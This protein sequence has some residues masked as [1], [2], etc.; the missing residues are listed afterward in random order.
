MDWPVLYERKVRFS[1]T[2]AQGVVFNGMYATY[3]DDTITDY[4]DAIGVPWSELNASGHD[5]VL[6][7]IEIDFRSSGR[8]GEVLVTGARVKRIGNSSLVFELRT[9][10]QSSGRT[11]AEAVQVQ[12]I[13]DH[14]TFKP[15]PVPSF[16]SDAVVRTQGPPPER[17][18]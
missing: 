17:E 6:A 4:F 8:F 1:D 15:V 14:A 3:F 7:R 16:L 12:V 11:V 13:V 5:M 18:G 10:E 2:D 9:W